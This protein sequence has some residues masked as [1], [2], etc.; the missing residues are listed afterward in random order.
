MFFIKWYK[1]GLLIVGMLEEL[2]FYIIME[3]LLVFMGRCFYIIRE[4]IL[5][6]FEFW[7]EDEGLYKCEVENELGKVFY[8]VSFYVEMSKCF[9][10]IW[11]WI[12]LFDLFVIIFL[13]GWWV[14]D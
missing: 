10:C 11:L 9:C 1:D 5:V 3:G 4:G 12:L 8:E 13:F 14:F 6:I 7:V 2:C